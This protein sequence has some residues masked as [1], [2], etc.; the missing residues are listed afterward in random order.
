LK[1]FRAEK[2]TLMKRIVSVD[3]CVAL[4]FLAI[5]ARRARNCC[6]TDDDSR[7]GDAPLPIGSPAG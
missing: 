7:A 1:A 2:K 6:R 3:V 5:P 4:L